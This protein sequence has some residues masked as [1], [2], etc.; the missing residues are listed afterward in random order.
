MVINKVQFLQFEL[1][2]REVSGMGTLVLYSTSS[3]LSSGSAGSV[4]GGSLEWGKSATGLGGPYG[5]LV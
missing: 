3:S 4:I 1:I 5:S 2:E